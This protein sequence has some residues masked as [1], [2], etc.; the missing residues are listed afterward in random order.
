MTYLLLLRASEL[1]AEDDGMLKR[2]MWHSM[3]VSGKRKEGEARRWTQWRYVSEDRTV[4]KVKE[5]RFL[6][7]QEVFGERGTKQWRR[8]RSCTE[9]MEGDRNFR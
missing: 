8:C 9:S 1:F 4:I 6:C 7:G 3:R 2:G 5:G